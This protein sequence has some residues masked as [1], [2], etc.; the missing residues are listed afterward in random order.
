[1]TFSLGEKSNLF[2]LF[3]SKLIENAEPDMELDLDIL[4]DMEVKTLWNEKDDYQFIESVFPFKNKLP[5]DTAI[6][7]KHDEDA[8]DDPF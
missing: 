1:M 3:V 8:G 6:E 5:A 2:K 7:Q 4:Q